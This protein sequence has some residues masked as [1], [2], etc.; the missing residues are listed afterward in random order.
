[1]GKEKAGKAL[2][3]AVGA[4]AV[5]L[6]FLRPGWDVWSLHAGC[7]AWARLAWPFLHANLLHA[8]LN[9][10]CLLSV[11]FVYD[12]S[13]KRLLLSY[14]V[15]VTIPVGPLSFL[16][17]MA[18]PTVGLSGVVYFLFAAGP[19]QVGRR[20]DWPAWLAPYLH[21]G[22]L[23]PKTNAWVHVWCYLAGLVFALLN[24]PIRRR[25]HGDQ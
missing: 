16:P 17:G 21:A 7:S 18:L 2:A 6:S 8:L 24:M 13:W 11:T 5:G 15:A 14:A 12:L 22:V 3:L 10:W 4:A 19:V 1:M 20:G 23:F 25:G 9:V